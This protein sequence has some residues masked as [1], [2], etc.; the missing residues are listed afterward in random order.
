MSILPR[1]VFLRSK[2]YVIIRGKNIFVFR[3]LIHNLL[4]LIINCELNRLVTN[5][6]LLYEVK[7][8]DH[9]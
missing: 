1:V 3:V 6:N 7:Q 9:G 5:F 2:H 4:T 8:V